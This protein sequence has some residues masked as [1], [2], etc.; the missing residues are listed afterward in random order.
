MI[1]R[2]FY[3]FI[4]IIFTQPFCAQ[5]IWS[6]SKLGSSFGLLA[7]DQNQQSINPAAFAVQQPKSITFQLDFPVALSDVMS[8]QF[9]ANYKW[10][11]SYVFHEL[12]GV[13]H[14]AQT[15]YHLTNAIALPLSA[16]LQ[17]GIALEGRLF[18]QPNYYG[19]FFKLSSRMGLSY[20]FNPQHYFSVVLEDIAKSQ[21][22][23][24]RLEHLWCISKQLQFAQGLGWNAAQR[25]VIYLSLVQYFGAYRIH[26][27]VNLPTN[28]LQL[29]YTHR[30]TKNWNYQLTQSWQVG[31]GYLIQLNFTRK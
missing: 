3:V 30:L 25:P 29:G 27:A 23:T 24:L 10:Q 12:R 13:F 15:R 6:T 21:I 26:F 9:Q 8:M 22:Q 16:Q 20:Q 17:F 19:N 4:T 7:L 5:S 11:K 18:I 28:H 14:S 2:L 1:S 31:I